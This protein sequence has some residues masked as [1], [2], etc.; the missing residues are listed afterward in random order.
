MKTHY[1]L[2]NNYHKFKIMIVMKNY[3][4]L[5]CSVNKEKVFKILYKVFYKIMK[6]IFCKIKIKKDQFVLK[7]LIWNF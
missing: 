5:K 1:N 2:N 4:W 3:Q 7:K 6:I